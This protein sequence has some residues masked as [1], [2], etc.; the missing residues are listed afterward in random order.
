VASKRHQCVSEQVFSDN[1][2][3]SS[4]L[5]RALSIDILYEGWCALLF[6]VLK[7]NPESYCDW[8]R[9][10]SMGKTGELFL[11]PGYPMLS[12]LNDHLVDVTYSQV[13]AD[14]LKQEATGLI[15][16]LSNESALS[17]LRKI[18]AICDE[19]QKQNLSIYLL[20]P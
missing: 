10:W 5:D 8:A 9:E 11:V 3:P 20:S 16:N 13:E 14:A 12:R 17:L 1:F 4:D 2:G 19:A 6:D 7:A 18:L 15:A